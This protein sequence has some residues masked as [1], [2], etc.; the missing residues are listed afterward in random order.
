MLALFDLAPN[1]TAQSKVA[2]HHV[3][4]LNEMKLRPQRSR[5]GREGCTV[6]Q[7][8]KTFSGMSDTLAILAPAAAV[9]KAR[10]WRGQ[11]GTGNVGMQSS[12]VSELPGARLAALF[13]L[14]PLGCRH[15]LFSSRRL[16][17]PV[18]I[19]RLN[20]GDVLTSRNVQQTLHS[21]RSALTPCT[22]IVVPSFDDSADRHHNQPSDSSSASLTIPSEPLFPS[23]CAA[24][25]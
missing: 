12:I 16:A 8:E 3:G 17:G 6:R 2:K 14:S 13:P 11:S 19:R 25:P 23:L 20:S 1:S 5:V 7:V 22:T 4:I 18:S 24:L 9:L 15:L 21:L 10:Q